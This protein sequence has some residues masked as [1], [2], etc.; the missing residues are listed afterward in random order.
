MRESHKLGFL[1]SSH[2]KLSV[3]ICTYY[4]GA[5][6][7]PGEFRC[8]RLPDKERNCCGTILNDYQVVG[9]GMFSTEFGSF[10]CAEFSGNHSHEGES[11]AWHGE[12]RPRDNKQLL[13]MS[14]KA[15]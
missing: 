6:S 15:K 1:C 9:S 7:C 10:L 14:S 3:V 8:T 11:K 2:R 12:R 4:D 13:G 5:V